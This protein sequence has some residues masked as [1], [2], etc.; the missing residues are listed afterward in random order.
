MRADAMERA[1]DKLAKLAGQGL[2]LVPLW[3]EATEVIANAVRHYAAPCWYTFDPA[4]LMV[5]SHFHEGLAELPRQW[6][7]TEY[8]EDDVYK[9]ADVARSQRGIITLHEATGGDPA[10]SKRWHNNITYG[11]DQELVAGLRTKDGTVWGG[12]SLYRQREEPLFTCEE[13]AFVRAVSGH[14]AE[15]ARRALLIGEA[16]DREW[17]DAPGLIVLSHRWQ[18]EFMSPGIDPWLDD[19]PDGDT[20]TGELPSSVLA[21][22]GRALR[23]ASG[24]TAGDPPFARVLSRS[25][26]WI[27][28]HGTA[29]VTDDSRRA[30]VI[31][32]PAHPTR[33]SPLLMSAYGLTPRERDI[34]RLVLSGLSTT[35]IADELVLST[36]TIQQHLKSIFEKTGVHSRREL[37]GKVFFSHYEPRVRDNEH[38]AATD[39]PLRGG[40]VRLP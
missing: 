30:A 1:V 3:R 25:G 31:I 18:I 8:C 21:I 19:L 34:T 32:E 2:G 20:R 26:T 14:L 35:Q 40:P 36:H 17:P 39:L 37:T 22:A 24:D 16:T 29:L 23:P 15:G 27:T 6:L 7:A 9:L 10:R 12:V 13:L 4:S 38:R 28:L 5:T 11:G 33:I